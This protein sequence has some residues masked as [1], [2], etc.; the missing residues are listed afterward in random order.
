MRRGLVMTE[1]EVAAHN[2]KVRGEKPAEKRE[3]K[4][5]KRD[6]ARELAAQIK[7]AGLPMPILEYAFDAQL[8][9]SGRVWRFDLAWIGWLAVEVDGAVHR[10]KGRFKG[11]RAKHQAAFKLGYKLLRVSP[12]QV[13]NGEA[14]EL[15]RKAIT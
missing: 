9:G 15:V 12:E 3:V 10:I 4:R 11:D 2:A 7:Q 14:L 1:A 5:S 13:R 6:Y 8:D